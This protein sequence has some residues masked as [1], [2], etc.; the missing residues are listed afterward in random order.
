[1][2]SHFNNE[3]YEKG[4]VGIPSLFINR[5]MLIKALINLETHA[6]NFGESCDRERKRKQLRRGNREEEISFNWFLSELLNISCHADQ[7]K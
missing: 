6:I 2:R 5:R 1:M 7:I 3:R 4:K